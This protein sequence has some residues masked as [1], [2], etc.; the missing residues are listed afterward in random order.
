MSRVMENGTN[1]F[2]GIKTLLTLG[3]VV[4][5]LIA[6]F[7]VVRYEV[8]QANGNSTG[9][10]HGAPSMP[11]VAAV[12]IQPKQVTL[13]TELPGRTSSY[14]MAEVRPQVSGLIQKRLFTE[15]S[16]IRAGQV[17]Y[18]IDPAPFQAAV[19]NAKANLLGAQK[20]AGQARASMEAG[21]AGVEQ[22]K[23][24]LDL[25]LT[26]KKRIENLVKGGAVSIRER[27]QAVSDAEVAQA[28]LRSAEAQVKAE[29][30]AI[31]VA[32]AAIRQAEA[33]LETVRINLG[34]T[35]ITAPISGRI[36]RSNVTVGA[37]VTAH[38]TVALATIQQM[39][40]LYVDVPQ[41]TTD[42]L[43]LRRRL[44]GGEINQKGKNQNVVRLMLEDGTEYP[45]EGKLQFR[46]V[47]V[48]QST[49]S[50]VLRVLFPNPDGILLPGMFVRAVIMEGVNE[51]AILVPQQA[52][53]RDPKGNPLTLV[54]D[55]AGKVEQRM[56]QLDRAVG[57]Q[58]LVGSGLTPGERV[59][60]EGSQRAR[61]GSTVK[62]VAFV[63]T[64]ARHA[65][66][67]EKVPPVKAKN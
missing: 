43:R 18:Q 38:Q 26:N 24:V 58:W 42:M 67:D 48:D 61:P 59:I 56:L 62:V 51:K 13:T 37:L 10:S 47:T 36:G 63:E 45:L 17:L 32:D 14:L 16:D 34:Y 25:A 29:R 65:G 27:D 7:Y 9:G 53:S 6:V 28:T 50:V 54:V 33:A 20:G 57:D 55:G 44:E 3:G 66:P 41:S 22:Q 4:L 40:P 52:V 46:D 2:A 49:G 11:E 60:V 19:D 39:D 12:E 30:E 5:A 1:G 35:S 8:P 21:L 23:A 15:G 31:Q 64:D